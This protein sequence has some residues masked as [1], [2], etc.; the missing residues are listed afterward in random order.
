MGPTGPKVKGF[1]LGSIQV[2]PLRTTRWACP[3][4]PSP[5]A[6]AVPLE[7]TIVARQPA[8]EAAGLGSAIRVHRIPSV[9][10]QA[11]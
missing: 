9:D 1:A 4:S 10:C 6:T 2:D 8:E 7:E 11:S 3:G 5:T